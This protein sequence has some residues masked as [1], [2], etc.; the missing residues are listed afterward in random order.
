MPQK[1]QQSRS[2]EYNNDND[3]YSINTDDLDGGGNDDGDAG[4]DAIGDDFVDREKTQA[5]DPTVASRDAS[6]NPTR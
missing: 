4:N 1:C 6:A 5:A 2:G 3:N